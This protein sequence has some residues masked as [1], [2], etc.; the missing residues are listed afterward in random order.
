MYAPIPITQENI[1]HAVREWLS[2]RDV[3]CSIYGPIDAWNTTSV[4]NMKSLFQDANGFQGNIGKWDVSNVVTMERMFAGWRSPFDMN[5]SAWNVS[6]V[7]NF[8]M[9]FWSVNF[10]DT[11]QCWCWDISPTANQEHNL[12]VLYEYLYYRIFIN[13]ECPNRE[14]VCFDNQSIR[15]AVGDWHSDDE[16]MLCYNKWGNISEWN[17]TGVTNIDE[18]FSRSQIDLV[19]LSQ[20]DTSNMVSMADTFRSYSGNPKSVAA[21]DVGSVTN[22]S[23]MFRDSGL[24]TDLSS[25][26]TSSAEDMSY[27]FAFTEN[28]NSDL[29]TWSTG[30]VKQFAFMF[31]SA[32]SFN[33]NLTA[34]DMSSVESIFWMFRGASSF[35]GLLCWALKPGAIMDLPVSENFQDS[36]ARLFDS[37]CPGWPLPITDESIYQAMLIRWE[38]TPESYNLYGNIAD[39]DTSDVTSM[40]RLFVHPEYGGMRVD[41]DV[42]RWNVAKV[43]DFSEMFLHVSGLY[44][45]LSSWKLASAKNISRMFFGA[46]DFHQLLCRWLDSLAE[47]IDIHDAFGRNEGEYWSSSRVDRERQVDSRYCIECSICEEGVKNPGAMALNHLHRKTIENIFGYSQ[48]MQ[49]YLSITCEELGRHPLRVFLDSVIWRESLD[50]G[51]VEPL[52]I[53]DDYM[54]H[55]S[56]AVLDAL[57]SESC[58][59]TAK[60]PKETCGLCEDGKTIPNPGLLLGD[61]STCEFLDWT[62]TAAH[63]VRQVDLGETDCEDFKGT[64]PS[65]DPGISYAEALRILGRE[66]GCSNQGSPASGLVAPMMILFVATILLGV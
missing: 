34:W 25:W 5:L 33:A 27:M 23:G 40:R 39:W 42:S 45:D 60:D 50:S 16:S 4:T 21:W 20:W 63:G 10:A 35:E 18:L 26:N 19:D 13:S 15:R 47:G 62:V 36:K 8:R 6:H 22:F 38:D 48:S 54:C 2:D 37:M 53:S 28:F 52:E 29:S 57:V 58:C 24:D 32:L 3:A 12:G 1:H 59:G 44:K 61:G 17:T 56:G 31:A 9:M 51:L 43:E 65:P 7:E 49:E 41:V 14:P 55:V 11:I 46:C 30:N 66:C 64:V